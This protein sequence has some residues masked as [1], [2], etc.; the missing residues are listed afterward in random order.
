MLRL[1]VSVIFIVLALPAL[2]QKE[3]E[4]YYIH[5]GASMLLGK[6]VESETNMLSISLSNG[7]KFRSGLMLG[8][9]T[10]IE[11]MTMPLLPVYAELK[12]HP[13][14]SHVSPFIFLRSG[15]AFSLM[16][17][18]EA[19]NMYG[20]TR[21]SKGGFL[22]NTGAGI[23]LQTWEKVGINIALGYRFQQVS[24]TE[25][26]NWTRYSYATESVTRFNR[27]ELQLGLVFR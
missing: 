17:D 20:Y 27:L 15:Y 10:G 19:A 14:P 21:E 3:P 24:V 1:G 25:N 9:G 8:I 6:S 16:G 12:Y 2:S 13:F 18:D 7:Y 5:F 26:N 11:E 22:I 23:L 4:G